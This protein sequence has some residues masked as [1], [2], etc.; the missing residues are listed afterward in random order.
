MANLKRVK[1]MYDYQLNQAHLDQFDQD[2]QMKIITCEN[3]S[4]V[5]QVLKIASECRVAYQV[6]KIEAYEL[7]DLFSQKLLAMG[8]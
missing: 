2:V 1:I 5:L 7:S 4:Q 6:G 8:V 3:D